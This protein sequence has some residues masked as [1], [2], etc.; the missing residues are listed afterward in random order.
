MEKI[1]M[2]RAFDGEVFKTENECAEYE[3]ALRKG[4]SSVAMDFFNALSALDQACARSGCR[5]CPFHS[6]CD[7]LGN[8]GSK[9]V[10]F[11]EPEWK[12][13]LVGIKEGD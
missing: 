5:D 7:K 10:E 2:Y 3:T 12:E 8:D 4:R 9:F 1:E 11:I 13:I 6:A